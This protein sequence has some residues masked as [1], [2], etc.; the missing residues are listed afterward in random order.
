MSVHSLTAME[1]LQKL[2]SFHTTYLGKL[3]CI[4]HAPQ[5]NFHICLYFEMPTFCRY[6]T[7]SGLAFSTALKM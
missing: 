1:I 2:I 7:F 4:Q 5:Q 6:S 3:L